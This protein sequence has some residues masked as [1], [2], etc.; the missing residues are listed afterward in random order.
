[1]S[2]GS[3]ASL[4][5]WSPSES[6][7]VLRTSDQE[8]PSWSSDWIPWPDSDLPAEFKFV[9]CKNRE[10]T[11]W[12]V[13]ANRQLTMG[14]SRRWAIS[15]DFR[16]TEPRWQPLSKPRESLKG[17]ASACSLSQ[18]SE[19]D[20]RTHRRKIQR[21]AT[22]GCIAEFLEGTV[23][24]QCALGQRSLFDPTGVASIKRG[25]QPSD[26]LCGA[27]SCHILSGTS[28]EKD[29]REPACTVL[30]ESLP[31]LGAHQGDSCHTSSA[32]FTRS[33]SFS[34]F[35]AP[36]MDTTL[37]LSRQSTWSEGLGTSGMRTPKSGAAHRERRYGPRRATMPEL[38]KKPDNLPLL[39]DEGELID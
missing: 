3:T 1:M 31:Q 39:L 12:E 5:N 33:A 37:S 9:I 11:T 10:G 34:F 4:G 17:S 24:T 16:K 26:A 23:S 8:F 2:V 36:T 27:D 32:T 18:M 21:A 19:E 38:V 22:F 29:V 7:V 30:N 25:K 6:S 15:G 20:A 14:S 28:T 35:S 13:G